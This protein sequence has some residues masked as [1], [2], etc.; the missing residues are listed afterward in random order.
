[1]NIYFNICL[2]IK[3]IQFLKKI[4]VLLNGSRDHQNIQVRNHYELSIIKCI[5]PENLC[6]MKKICTQGF[7]G[8]LNGIIVTFFNRSSKIPIL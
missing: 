8:T 2:T 7:D 1:M 4:S 5:Y 3:N 6:Y